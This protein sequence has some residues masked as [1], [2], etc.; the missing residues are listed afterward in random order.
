[1]HSVKGR[2]HCAICSYICHTHTHTNANVRSFCCHKFQIY[3]VYRQK[4]ANVFLMQLFSLCCVCMLYM[5]CIVKQAKQIVIKNPLIRVFVFFCESNFHPTVFLL[6]KR[7]TEGA[8]E[9]CNIDED[10]DYNG[11]NKQRQQQQLPQKQWHGSMLKWMLFMC[12]L[13]FS[14]LYIVCIHRRTHTYTHTT[15]QNCCSKISKKMKMKMKMCRRSSRKWI[16]GLNRIYYMFD[17]MKR[18]I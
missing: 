8:C 4:Q 16:Y 15:H 17:L 5:L 18:A 3:C 13:M 14:Y 11:G 2:L 12:C 1:M 10:K 6:V 7:W 9:A